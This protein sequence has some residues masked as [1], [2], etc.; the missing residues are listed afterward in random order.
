MDVTHV[1]LGTILSGMILIQ[2][3]VSARALRDIEAGLERIGRGLERIETGLERIETGLER[4]MAG[5]RELG[6]T[7]RHIHRHDH[8][9]GPHAHPDEPGL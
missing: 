1:L 3:V 8:D 4:I 7:L 6:N 9:L 5:S 2:T